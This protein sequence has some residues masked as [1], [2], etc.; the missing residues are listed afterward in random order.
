MKTIAC[1]LGILFATSINAQKFDCSSKTKAYQDLLQANKMKESFDIWTEVKKNCPKENEAVYTDG[2]KILEYRTGMASGE[3]KEKSAREL[4]KLYD[5][6]H[7]NFPSSVTDFEVRK[8]MVLV[9][10]RIGTK[11]EIFT[12]LDNGFNK[13]AKD[14]TDVRAI[15]TYFSTY[16]ERFSAGDKKI[17]ADSVLEKYTTISSLLT[18]LSENNSDNKDYKATKN[19]IDRLI[20]D[21][22]TCDNL[23]AFYTKNYAANQENANWITSALVSLSGNCGS[24]PIFL[25]LAEKLYAMKPTAQ[26]AN[27]VA[28]AYVKERKLTEAIKFYEE[29]AALETIPAEKAKT[30]YTLATSLLSNDLPKSKETIDKALAA[31]PKMGKAYLFLAELYFNNANNCSSSDFEKKA[32][33]Y[34]GIQTAQKAGAAEPR[35]KPTS[36]KIAEDYA[37]KSLTPEEIS[38]QKMNGKSLTIGCWINETVSFPSKK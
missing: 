20:K 26:S 23:A 2:I 30:Y 27:F 11:D 25:T 14:I 16:V 22:A 29:S 19:A 7:L 8:A 18:Q 5:Q 34:L 28:L 37:S 9:M 1:L 17:T 10:N 13:A 12:L 32:I 3:E 21:I 36:D 24:K 6:Y 4:M 33:I 31:D 15:H 35:L 38:K